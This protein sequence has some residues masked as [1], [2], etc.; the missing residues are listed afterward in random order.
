M[1]N[2]ML[3]YFINLFFHKCVNPMTAARIFV[4][5]SLHYYFL[6]NVILKKF[7][8]IKYILI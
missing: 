3:Y 5:A 8:Y 2:Y 6:Y 7:F 4:I 1:Y